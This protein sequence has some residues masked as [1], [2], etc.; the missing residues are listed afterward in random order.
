MATDTTK[1][2]IRLP[3][4]DVE[5]AK[6]CAKRHGISVTELIDRS[7]RQLRRAEQDE[8]PGLEAISGL[9]P[10]EVDAVDDYRQHL[11]VK[12]GGSRPASDS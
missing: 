10:A 9:I 3:R 6:A 11:L 2:T 8:V 1:L 12:H 5:F 4:Q 7:V